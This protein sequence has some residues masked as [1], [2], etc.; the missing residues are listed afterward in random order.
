MSA[1]VPA[2]PSTR[3]A[4]P[5]TSQSTPAQSRSQQDLRRLTQMIQHDIAEQSKFLSPSVSAAVKS[6]GEAKIE[7]LFS[8]HTIQSQALASVRP[9]TAPAQRRAQTDAVIADFFSDKVQ[10]IPSAISKQ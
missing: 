6:E 5:D 8:Q 1:S 4:W 9:M 7:S 10:E 3:L 2:L